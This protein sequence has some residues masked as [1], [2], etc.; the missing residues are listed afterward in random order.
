VACAYVTGWWKRDDGTTDTDHLTAEI[1]HR[2]STEIAKFQLEDL[3]AEEWEQCVATIGE[4]DDES[5]RAI[6]SGWHRQLLVPSQHSADYWPGSEFM[7]FCPADAWHVRDDF[8]R[9]A[10]DYDSVVAF[11]NRWGHWAGGATDLRKILNL[12]SQVREAL[13]SPPDRWFASPVPSYPNAW[14]RDP[15]YPFFAVRT[16]H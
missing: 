4:E 13:S 15:K 8:L 11:L 16:C 3:P 2:G 14:K 9:M 7:K 10:P 5:V 12:Q 1:S 6:C